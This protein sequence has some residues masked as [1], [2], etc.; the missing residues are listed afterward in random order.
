MAMADHFIVMGDILK[1][2]KYDGKE[3]M[4]DFKGLVSSC[5][6][7]LGERRR[8]TC[9]TGI[10]DLTDLTGGGLIFLQWSCGKSYA[11]HTKGHSGLVILV[12]LTF[13]VLLVVVFQFFSF[14]V[15]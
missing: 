13:L 3:L 8:L 1:S 6:R 9:E 15:F 4:R 7:K 12:F 11:V 10:S 2:S 5:N 14:L